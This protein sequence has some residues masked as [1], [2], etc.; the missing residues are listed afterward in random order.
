MSFFGIAPY[1]GA[2]SCWCGREPSISE[3]LAEPIVGA[4]ME[5]DGVNPDELA[6]LLRK[7][8]ESL[9]NA[10]RRNAPRRQAATKFFR[11]TPMLEILTAAGSIASVVAAIPIVGK[12]RRA[13]SL[14]CKRMVREMTENLRS[15]QPQTEILLDNIDK[16]MKRLQKT[17]RQTLNEI[18][19]GSRL[20]EADARMALTLLLPRERRLVVA[21]TYTWEATED[22]SMPSGV[23][24][25]CA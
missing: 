18:A 19:I 2:G 3:I 9:L 17:S 21:T 13:R 22:P 4:V 25:R 11:S 12:L 10:S 20:S 24:V 1:I 5:A 14:L 6:A 23:G 8:R 15:Y 16:V 7:A